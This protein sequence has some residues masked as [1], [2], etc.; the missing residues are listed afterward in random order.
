MNE[1]TQSFP[2][3]ENDIDEANYTAS[4]ISLCAIH[5]IL[6]ENE[7][8][9]IRTGLDK[10]FVE[11]AE[12]FT[13][14]ESSTIPKETAEQFYSSLLYQCDIALMQSKAVQ[15]AIDVLKNKDVSDILAKG[16]SI[17]LALHEDSKRIFQIAFKNRLHLPIYSYG[18]MLEK[19]FDEYCAGYSARFDAKN[20]ITSIDYPLLGRPAYS[21]KTQ[22]VLFIHEYYTA[23]MYE[24]LF[25]KRFDEKNIELLLLCFGKQNRVDYRDMFFNISEVVL[26]NLI[27][28]VL[29]QKQPFDLFLSKEDIREFEEKYQNDSRQQFDEAVNKAFIRLEG[30]IHDKDCFAYIKTYAPTLSADLYERVKMNHL[31]N[32]LVVCTSFGI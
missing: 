27:V 12:Q 19:A 30:F 32:Y 6:S 9:K 4:L 15:G 14:R 24:N 31:E 25:C 20:I 2:F 3:S 29:L 22:G 17:I 10:A 16:K 21:L 11:T 1:L 7:L 8:L 28:N 23:I 26:N 18:Y 5:N 13:K